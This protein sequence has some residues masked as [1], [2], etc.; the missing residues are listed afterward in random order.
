MR[1]AGS[2]SRYADLEGEGDQHVNTPIRV[3][4]Y[5]REYRRKR[6]TSSAN[7]QCIELP[8]R[9]VKVGRGVPAGKNGGSPHSQRANLPTG[10]FLGHV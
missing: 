10:H 1:N 8:Q 9:R 3:V 6:G 5:C 2:S 4:P 7:G